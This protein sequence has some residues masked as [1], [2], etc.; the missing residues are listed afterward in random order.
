M[1]GCGGF[2][3]LLILRTLR[4]AWNKRLRKMMMMAIKCDGDGRKAICLPLYHSLAGAAYTHRYICREK[5]LPL[6]DDLR[7]L[8]TSP[9]TLW[10]IRVNKLFLTLLLLLQ[11]YNF[12]TINP[13]I[14]L[15]I[16][17]YLP[18]VNFS[19]NSFEFI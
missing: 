1:R 13:Q 5:N 4:G 17:W 15:S 7:P 10:E 8:M 6:R 16:F 2:F 18:K 19:F 3:I 12:H 9:P 11:S 14:S